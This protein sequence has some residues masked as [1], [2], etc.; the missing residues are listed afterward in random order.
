MTKAEIT[1]K[2]CPW[3]KKTPSISLPIDNKWAKDIFG[4]DKLV[5]ETWSW[6]I[7]CHCKVRSCTKVNV[8]KTQQVTLSKVLD[9][10]NILASNWN[11]QNPEKSYETIIVS[12]DKI[13]FE[14]A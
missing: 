2:P 9:K 4:K 11:F 12:L 5:Y 13:K 3:C 6:E 10:L 1:L 14:K 7:Y 8:R